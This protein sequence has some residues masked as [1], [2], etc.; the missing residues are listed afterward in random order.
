MVRFP[1]EE[2]RVKDGES[3]LKYIGAVP[4]EAK[5]T[6]P[7]VETIGRVIRLQTQH[8]LN[9][10]IEYLNYDGEV[11]VISVVRSKITPIGPRT[12]TI[13]RLLYD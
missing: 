9:Y 3:I 13:W 12:T 2:W 1:I 7:K 10:D 11:D 4:P 8:C 6:V 5:D